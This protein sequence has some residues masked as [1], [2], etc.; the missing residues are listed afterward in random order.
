MPKELNNFEQLLEE[1]AL[2]FDFQKHQ[3]AKENVM[4]TLDSYKLIGQLV[5]VFVP[6]MVNVLIAATKSGHT[7]T[8]NASSSGKKSSP[9]PH[10]GQGPTDQGPR[11]PDEDMPTIR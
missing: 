1:E 7:S 8:D 3:Q 2:R 10:L 11:L 9:P 6:D 4:N 5:T